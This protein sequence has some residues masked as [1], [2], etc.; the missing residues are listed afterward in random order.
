MHASPGRARACIHSRRMHVAL[1][2]S[3]QMC[4]PA[5]RGAPRSPRAP[6]LLSLYPLAIDDTGVPGSGGELASTTTAGRLGARWMVNVNWP[7]PSPSPQCRSASGIRALPGAMLV[8]RVSVDRSYLKTLVPSE[9]AARPYTAL[10]ERLPSTMS[11][12]LRACAHT[13]A[14]GADTNGRA[15]KCARGHATRWPPVAHQMGQLSAPHSSVDR[16]DHA[17]KHRR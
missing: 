8:S 3:R 9:L 16:L 15:H 7:V 13:H 4:T 6:I 1:T 10:S 2:I 12:D 11:P 17:R 5:C 14:R